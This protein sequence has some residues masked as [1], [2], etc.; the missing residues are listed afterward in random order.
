VLPGSA[1]IDVAR[2]RTQHA[3]LL[4]VLR[5]VGASIVLAPEGPEAS[6]WSC[7]C[8]DL[9]AQ[10]GALL[11]Y[12]RP[13]HA[14][15][16]VELAWALEQAGAAPDSI[17]IEA[18]GTLEGA[19]IVCEDDFIY[20][21]QSARTNHAALKQ[22]ALALLPHGKLVKAIEVRRVTHLG[23]AC[24]PIGDGAWLVHA[25]HIG[26][27]R[28]RGLDAIEVPQ[29]EPH[30]AALLALPGLGPATVLGPGPRG[31]L[32]VPTSAPRTAEALAARGLAVHLCDLSEFERAGIALR[33]LVWPIER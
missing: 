29:D 31:A 27:S 1:P 33:S 26:L 25:Q 32:I 22:L 6:P 19:D 8:G 24:T 13:A 10:L 28:V 21:G 11:L 12:A 17:R 23:N 20:V 7:C 3:A 18:P 9:G 16:R 4:D 14:E 2:A 5:G 15:R 30:G